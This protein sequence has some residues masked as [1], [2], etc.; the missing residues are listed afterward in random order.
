M[1]TLILICISLLAFFALVPYRWIES[2]EIKALRSI[3]LEGVQDFLNKMDE[4]IQKRSFFKRAAYRL[5]LWGIF[6]KQGF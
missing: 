6:F 5:R 1:T 3:D 2:K 4:D